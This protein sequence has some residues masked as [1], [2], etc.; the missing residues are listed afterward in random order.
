MRHINVVVEGKKDL[1]FLHEFILQRFG[2]LFDRAENG[3]PDDVKKLGKKPYRMKS[4][5]GVVVFNI[6]DV[7]GFGKVEAYS[8]ILKRPQELA[9][10]DEFVSAVIFD[11]D[12]TPPIGQS[13]TNYAGFSSR[14]QHILD[15][16]KVTDSTH[17]QKGLALIFLFPDNQSDGDIETLMEKMIIP[18]RN[19]LEFINVCWYNFEHCV[20]AHGF[21]PT[22]RKSKMNEYTAAF[23][24]LAW[25]YNGIN[26]CFARP[27]LWDWNAQG[28]TPLFDFVSKL[29]V[30]SP[31]TSFDDA[32]K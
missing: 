29:L 13:N 2:Q 20:K 15:L 18:T 27:N 1:Y 21:N 28:L 32:L 14:P 31:P 8:D 25:D 9:D 22:T 23:D 17:R 5:D 11:A 19:H 16:L 3:I 10:T 26:R 7:E 12:K 6:Y 4:N 30:S 24:S